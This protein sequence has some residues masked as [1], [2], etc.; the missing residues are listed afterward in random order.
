MAKRVKEGSSSVSRPDGAE[1]HRLFRDAA[2]QSTGRK[3]GDES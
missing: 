2:H 3:D 1:T